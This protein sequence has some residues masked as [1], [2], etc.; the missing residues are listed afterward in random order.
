[1][2]PIFG[3]PRAGALATNQLIHWDVARN[4]QPVEWWIWSKVEVDDVRFI[5]KIYGNNGYIMV[6]HGWWQT[7]PLKNDGVRQLG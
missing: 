1:M 2:V 5:G 6:K 3:L 7:T 4:V